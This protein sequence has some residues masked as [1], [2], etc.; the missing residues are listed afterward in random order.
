[1]RYVCRLWRVYRSDYL[2]CAQYYSYNMC[3]CRHNVVTLLVTLSVTLSQDNGTYRTIWSLHSRGFA[4]AFRGFWDKF[5]ASHIMVKPYKSF[6]CNSVYRVILI[7]HKIHGF[8]FLRREFVTLFKTKYH[9]EMQKFIVV[10]ICN[11]SRR[12]YMY[13]RE[14]GG[15]PYIKSWNYTANLIA[16][17]SKTFPSQVS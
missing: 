4:D 14:L 11:N 1:M 16:F 17:F 3:C 5:M 10:S 7:H 8:F 15:T 6:H 2:R 9:G 13:I 12:L